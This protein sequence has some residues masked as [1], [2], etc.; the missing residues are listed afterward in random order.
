MI[1]PDLPGGLLDLGDRTQRTGDHVAG[2]FDLGLGVADGARRLVGVGRRLLHASIDVSQ[3]SRGLFQRGGL[4]LGAARQVVRRRR[5]LVAVGAQGPAAGGHGGDGRFE[6]LERGI[7][8]RADAAVLGGHVVRHS[9]GE[10]AVRQRGGGGPHRGRHRRPLSGQDLRL[11][12]SARRLGGREIHRDGIVHVEQGGLDQR[13]SLRGD[14]V[15]VR[16]RAPEPAGPAGRQQ[17][18]HHRLDQQGVTAHVPPRLEADPGVGLADTH[19]RLHVAL[20]ELCGGY[21]P[22]VLDLAGLGA[23]HPRVVG[24]ERPRRRR[25]ADLVVEGVQRTGQFGH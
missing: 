17:R 20:V 3:R 2:S 16:P 11:G 22:P 13:A 12:L 24:E 1:W 7:E 5:Q 15:R 25:Y 4:L 10:V 9:V 19:H 6:P 18:R 14:L 21:G 23:L 8:V